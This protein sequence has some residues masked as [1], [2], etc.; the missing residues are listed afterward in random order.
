MAPHGCAFP[1]SEKPRVGWSSSASG[2]QTPR[3]R[4]TKGPASGPTRAPLG[5]PPA[6]RPGARSSPRSRAEARLRGAGFPLPRRP[7]ASPSWRSS[8]PANF[9]CAYPP[10]EV[11]GFS[12]FPRCPRPWSA[13]SSFSSRSLDVRLQLETPRKSDFL[14][15]VPLFPP[16]AA[17]L[18]GSALTFL[19]VSQAGV[20]AGSLAFLIW[21]PREEVG[22]V[23]SHTVGADAGK[24]NSWRGR[25]AVL[26]HS[27]CLQTYSTSAG[28]RTSQSQRLSLLPD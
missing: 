25:H 2:F 17:P 21:I 11:P 23:I 16:L 26:E 20:A 14:V 7:P 27:A 9:I 19:S 4:A 3:G 15:L 10:A 5:P 24:L 1:S 28:G 18:S 6:V 22:V 12:S 8:P 13:F